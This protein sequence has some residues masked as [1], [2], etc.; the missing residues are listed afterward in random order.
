MALVYDTGDLGWGMVVCAH[1]FMYV[2][3]Y[4]EECSSLGTSAEATAPCMRDLFSL[5]LKINK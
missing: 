3:V 4:S 5:A 1:V 2:H